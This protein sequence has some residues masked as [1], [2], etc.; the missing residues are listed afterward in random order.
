MR[1]WIHEDVSSEDR[2]HAYQSAIEE[3]V[4]VEE[5]YAEEE[6]VPLASRIRLV[7][8]GLIKGIRILVTIVV[9]SSYRRRSLLSR[10]NG[11]VKLASRIRLVITGLIKAIRILVTI[12]V[13]SS[14]R[15]RSLLSRQNGKVKEHYSLFHAASHSLVLTAAD[16]CCLGKKE[17]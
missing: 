6:R 13:G 11:K 17:K 9:G 8:T 1:P 3:A 16:H 14:Y 12:V 2:T 4:Y 7:I 5:R 15:R 10:E